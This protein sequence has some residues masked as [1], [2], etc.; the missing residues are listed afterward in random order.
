MNRYGAMA[1]QH[2][3]RWL[4]EHY[5]T[6]TDP[7]AFFAQMGEQAADQVDQIRDHL[8]MKAGPTPDHL[9]RAGLW[10]AVT[11][12]AEE[13]VLQQSVLAEPEAAMIDQ[14][15]DDPNYR[16][17]MDLVAEVNAEVDRETAAEAATER[18]ETEAEYL[19]RVRVEDPTMYE[20]DLA[21]IS[22]RDQKQNEQTQPTNRAPSSE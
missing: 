19:A 20:Q 16:S 11:Q 10:T 21:Y 14:D 5:A 17:T 3:A 6:I 9:A 13:I 4:P 12:Q 1:H 2:W 15:E 18:V 8:L 7:E 22:R